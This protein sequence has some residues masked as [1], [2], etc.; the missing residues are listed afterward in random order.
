MTSA[1]RFYRHGA[2]TG[3]AL[4]FYLIM[5]LSPI[6]RAE[7]NTG[8]T[9]RNVLSYAFQPVNCVGNLLHEVTGSLINTVYCV[10]GNVNR[11]PITL[12]PIIVTPSAGN[13]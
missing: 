5:A 6:T 2:I 4:A 13:L 11:N 3:G 10:I 8:L 9:V 1:T 7:A 12:D